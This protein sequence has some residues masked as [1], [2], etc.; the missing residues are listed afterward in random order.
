MKRHGCKEVTVIEIS[1]PR[2]WLTRSK[3]GLWYSNRD[4]PPGRIIQTIAVDE[5]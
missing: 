3:A 2:S 1:V 5:D 4:V